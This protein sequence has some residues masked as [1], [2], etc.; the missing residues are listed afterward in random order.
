MLA[1][2][3]N[4][5]CLS[6]CGSL[7]LSP[8]VLVELAAR[9]GIGIL[10]LT[11]HNSAANCPAFA[12]LC[13]QAGIVPL[14]GMEAT[15]REE[16]HVLCL[17]TH[18]DEALAFGEQVYTVLPPFPNDPERMGD[19]VV[20]NEYDEIEDVVDVYLGSALDL[21]LDAIGPLVEQ[22]GGLVIPAHIDRPSFSMTSQLGFV[23]PGPWAALECVRLPPSVDTFGYPLITGSDAHYPEHIGRR[24]FELP[25]AEQE[26]QIVKKNNRIDLELLR[27]ALQRVAPSGFSVTD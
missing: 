20:V 4:H 7:D 10:A 22:M 5:S 26:V 27:I 1:D 18:L 15:T 13:Y 8:R 9:R 25:L 16:V 14:F 12:K 24:S 6:P 19:Q 11:D 2:F 23:S 3:H 17:F 21:G